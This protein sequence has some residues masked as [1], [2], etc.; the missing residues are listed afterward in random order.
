M[1]RPH[2]VMNVVFGWNSL[3][4]GIAWYPLTASKTF[5]FCFMW[6]LVVP[7][8]MVTQYGVSPV[9]IVNSG[10]GNLHG[11]PFFLAFMTIVLHQSVSMP[12]VTGAIM[13]LSMSFQMSCFTDSL[14]WKGTG[15][16]LCLA[17]GIAPSLGWMWAAGS[18]INGKTPSSFNADLAKCFRS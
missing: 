14:K 4:N 3:S 12:T 17:L 1:N 10:A 18:D 7:T 2:F 15:I 6:L 16:G 8:G 13:L 11:L 9:Y 5:F